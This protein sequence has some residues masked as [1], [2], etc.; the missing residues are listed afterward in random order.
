MT[1]CTTQA[2]IDRFGESELIRLTE[3]TDDNGHY[4]NTL[5]QTQ[6]DS[7]IVDATATIDSYLAGRYPLPLAQ[8]PPVLDRFACDIARYFLHDRSP[9]E[10]VT[11]RYKEALRFLEKAASGSI[12]L[13]IDAQG[14]RPETN[15]GAVIESDGHVFSRKDKAFI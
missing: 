11:N 10:E 5:D 6:I 2:L 12:S 7:A 13:G 9:L 8:V 4:T 15:D 3:R 1:Y 14:K